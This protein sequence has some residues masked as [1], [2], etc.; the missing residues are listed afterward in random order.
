MSNLLEK[1]QSWDSQLV[2]AP[3]F[4]KEAFQQKLTEIA[5][6]T[7][8]DNGGLALM[9]ARIMQRQKHGTHATKAFL[10]SIFNAVSWNIMQFSPSLNKFRIAVDGQKFGEARISC[11]LFFRC[12]FYIARFVVTVIINSIQ[13]VFGRR[14][15][16]HFCQEHVERDKAKFYTATTVTMII[17]RV[18]ILASLFSSHIRL[19]LRHITSTVRSSNATTRL[20]AVGAQ[21]GSVYAPHCATTAL[22]PP[23]GSFFKTLSE[24]QNRPLSKRLTGQVNEISSNRMDAIKNVRIGIRHK[25]LFSVT[26]ANPKLFVYFSKIMDTIKASKEWTHQMEAAPAFDKSAYQEKL[27]SI[28]GMTTENEPVLKLVWGGSEAVWVNG[29][30]QPRYAIESMATNNFGEKLPLR[31]W[32]IEENTEPAQLEKMGGKNHDALE[33]PEKGFYTA[34]IIVGDHSK[35]KAD[36]S[37]KG[38]CLG[39][40]KEPDGA[41]L[42]L[43]IEHTMR[44]LTDKNRPDPRKQITPEMALPILQEE[45]YKNQ[46]KEEKESDENEAFV[47]S[48]FR[49]TTKNKVTSLPSNN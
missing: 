2:P 33:V 38:L 22:T 41:E 36:C 20:G 32:I 5:G 39:E 45:A 19:V 12:P 7:T 24:L 26:Y 29:E 35:C 13:R 31:R 28:A 6:K 43:I 11:L 44:L 47:K 23:I 34:Y 46:I 4:D 17:F 1:S 30:V 8:I 15:T 27:N 48:W 9:R 21:H 42:N 16:S 25:F 37:A 10:Q 14:F 40:Y 3:P 18:S 49:D